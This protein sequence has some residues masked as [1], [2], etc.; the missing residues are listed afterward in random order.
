MPYGIL[1]FL[2]FI[3]ETLGSGSNI[4]PTYAAFNSILSD[5]TTLTN[6]SN[7]P[8]VDGNPTDFSNLYSALKVCQS[9]AASAENRKTI[10][11]M[12]LQL[13]AKS[14]RLKSKDDINSDFIFRSGELHAVF[15]FLKV[16]G[17][18]IE[19]S[20]LDL[21][22]IESGIYGPT[23]LNQILQGKH[24]K[25]SIEAYLCLYL[26][27][28]KLY[29]NHL[30]EQNKHVQD[31]VPPLVSSFA[32]SFE[33]K[34]KETIFEEYSRILQVINDEKLFKCIQTF[35]KQLKGRAKVI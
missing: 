22:F 7:L 31:S 25:R 27:L 17:K 23:T 18:Y 6:I 10:V 13:C 5:N 29:I 4:M 8:P 20:G 24:M 34:E 28:F 9:I 15:A 32:R 19:N 3:F 16:I 1:D 33:T 2:W 30:F 12:D 35:D 21:V 14:M 26:A 11:S